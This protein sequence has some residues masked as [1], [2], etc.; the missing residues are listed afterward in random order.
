[1]DLI[2]VTEEDLL[3]YVPKEP[4]LLDDVWRS[5]LD[6]SIEARGFTEDVCRLGTGAAFLQDLAYTA[7]VESARP[8]P[9]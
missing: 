9:A 8:V 5:V 3:R 2:G 1:M 4:R 6:H 7:W